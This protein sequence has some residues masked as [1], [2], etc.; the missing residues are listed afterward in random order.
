M[1]IMSSLAIAVT[2]T[3]TSSGAALVPWAQARAGV[4]RAY[5]GERL[6]TVDFSVSCAAAVHA[7]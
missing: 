3:L 4:S 6:G 1:K 2:L 7:P 5:P